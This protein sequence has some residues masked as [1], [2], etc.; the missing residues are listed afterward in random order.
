SGVRRCLCVLD[1]SRLCRRKL[2]REGR[3]A[4]ADGRGHARLCLW[5]AAQL[6]AVVSDQG[7]RGPRWPRGADARASGLALLASSFRIAAR[8]ASLESTI[9]GQAEHARAG[10]MDSGLATELVI[11]P[12]TSGRTRWSRPGMTAPTVMAG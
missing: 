3:Q 1:L 9:T 2:A 4:F 6:P 11:G 12:A 8:A 10:V 5:R 7:H